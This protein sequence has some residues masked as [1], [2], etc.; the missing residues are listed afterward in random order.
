MS[1]VGSVNFCSICNLAFET[2]IQFIK[3][4]LRDEHLNSAR[5][6]MEDETIEREYDS[7]EECYFLRPKT[8]TKTETKTK[9]NTKDIIKTKPKT[10]TEVGSEAMPRHSIYSGIRFKCKECHAEFRNEIALNTH[11]YSYNREYLE[12]TE[13]FDK[14][15]SQ[16][17]KEFYITD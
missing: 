14:N 5:K 12:N 9:D 6:E 4:N 8:K 2:R 11:S 13:N 17:M 7:E 15:S 1:K 3:H 16:N 10:K